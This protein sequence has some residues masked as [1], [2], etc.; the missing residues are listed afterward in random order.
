MGGNLFFRACRF[1]G[2]AFRPSVTFEGGNAFVK[3]FAYSQLLNPPILSSSSQNPVF[4]PVLLSMSWDVKTMRIFITKS[5]VEQLDY[6]RHM[7][8]YDH[9]CAAGTRQ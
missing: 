6:Q 9:S 7:L 8:R 4:F 1:G 5:N 2:Y 3:I